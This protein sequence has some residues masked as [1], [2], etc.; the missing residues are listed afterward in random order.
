[1]TREEKIEKLEDQL[2]RALVIVKHPNVTDKM[3][4][5]LESLLNRQGKCISSLE[6]LET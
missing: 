1:M 5:Q 2:K 3:L 4:N 6:H